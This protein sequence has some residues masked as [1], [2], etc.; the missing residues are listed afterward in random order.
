MDA[1]KKEDLGDLVMIW[2]S[3][4]KDGWSITAANLRFESGGTRL[5]AKRPDTASQKKQI[6]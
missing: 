2:P 4:V 5:T 6:G 1:R 3:T